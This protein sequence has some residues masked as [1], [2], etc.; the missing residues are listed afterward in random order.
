MTQWKHWERLTCEELIMLNSKHAEFKDT[1]MWGYE[2]K[3]LGGDVR[4]GH[5]K[6]HQNSMNSE[7]P[8]LQRRSVHL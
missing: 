4:A 2:M 1:N 5:K 8:W 6:E 7:D 3:Q